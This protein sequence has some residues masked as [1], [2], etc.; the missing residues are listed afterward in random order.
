MAHGP[1]IDLI[2]STLNALDVGT[3]DSVRDKLR[4]VQEALAA[5]GQDD[6]ATRA[7]DGAQA[8]ALGNVAEFKRIRA[9]L[10]A[11]VGHLR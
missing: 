8:L 10:Q 9:F 2:L 3:L 11:K 6:L 1:Q 7:A 5:L 4:Q